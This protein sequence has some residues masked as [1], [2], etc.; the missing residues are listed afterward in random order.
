MGTPQ[1]MWK[2]KT[3]LT[4]VSEKK[5]QGKSEN[6]LRRIEIKTQDTKTYGI[7]PNQRGSY[8]YKYLH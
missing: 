3:L 6:I 8:S 5:S 1:K 7:H 2:L 4:N